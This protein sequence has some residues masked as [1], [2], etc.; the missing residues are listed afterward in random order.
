MTVNKPSKQPRAAK[1]R[2]L[3][4]S[5]KPSLADRYVYELDKRSSWQGIGD[6]ALAGDREAIKDLAAMGT[7]FMDA[8]ATKGHATANAATADAAFWALASFAR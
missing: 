6:A 3:P 8:L 5:D 7:V 1:A 4:A 2:A